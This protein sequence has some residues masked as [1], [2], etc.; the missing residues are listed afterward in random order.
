[1]TRAWKTADGGQLEDLGPTAEPVGTPL[2]DELPE[3]PYRALHEYLHLAA[4]GR[5]RRFAVQV[6]SLEDELGLTAFCVKD[7]ALWELTLQTFW[8]ETYRVKRRDEPVLAGLIP[9]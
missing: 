9:V 2:R 1:M 8:G 7:G 4:D 6:W 5:R 3:G